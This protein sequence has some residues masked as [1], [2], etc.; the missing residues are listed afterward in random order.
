M[1]KLVLIDSA[2]YFRFMTKNKNKNNKV[3]ITKQEGRVHH[4]YFKSTN[5]WDMVC[6]TAVIA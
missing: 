3:T 5:Y 4:R 2:H 6:P 1:F